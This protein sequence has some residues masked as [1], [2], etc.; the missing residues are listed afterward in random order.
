[1]TADVELET[2]L[3]SALLLAPIPFDAKLPIAFD[4][5]VG[6]V[7]EF[8]TGF[9]SSVSIFSSLRFSTTTELTCAVGGFK[10]VDGDFDS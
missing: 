5:G 1:M 2:A 8:V 7:E 4:G 10:T 6:N 9:G 3:L